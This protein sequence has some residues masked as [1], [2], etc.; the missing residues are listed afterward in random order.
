MPRPKLPPGR[1]KVNRVVL[2][3]DDRQVERFGRAAKAYGFDSP[4]DWLSATASG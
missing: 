4:A 1:A 2:Y 3:Q